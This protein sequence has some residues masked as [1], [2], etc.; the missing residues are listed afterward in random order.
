MLHIH[1]HTHIFSQPYARTCT[2]RAL[3]SCACLALYAARSL[4]SVCFQGLR[5]QMSWCCICANANVMRNS[6]SS[7][8][9]VR[10]LSWCCI[11][12]VQGC[13]FCVIG[14]CSRHVHTYTHTY[15]HTHTHL[16]LAESTHQPPIVLQAHS[17]ELANICAV[18]CVSRHTRTDTL[19][20]IDIDIHT[21]AHTCI[22]LRPHTS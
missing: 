18:S 7:S 3:N 21:H 2:S 4:I 11:C 12:T 15:T 19:T 17:L 16:Q 13:A 10:Q 20:S 6:F 9:N 14:A 22:L 8:L 1:K 5:H